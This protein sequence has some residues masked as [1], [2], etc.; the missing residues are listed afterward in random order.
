MAVVVNEQIGQPEKGRRKRIGLRRKQVEFLAELY[1]VREGGCLTRAQL[2]RRT[3]TNNNSVTHDSIGSYDPDIRARRDRDNGY[4][5]LITLG[6]VVVSS[7][8]IEG[9][10]EIVYE[11]TPAGRRAF[12]IERDK[13]RGSKEEG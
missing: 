8:L 12:E 10:R 2:C 3:G 7:M 9:L 6:Y 5:C 11:I 4:L 1:K 13:K